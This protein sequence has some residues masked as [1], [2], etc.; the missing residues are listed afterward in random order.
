MMRAPAIERDAMNG[1][2]DDDLFT[3]SWIERKRKFVLLARKQRP[4]SGAPYSTATILDREASNAGDGA[5]TIKTIGAL[6]RLNW[7]LQLRPDYAE[8]S[9]VSSQRRLLSN[10][11]LKLTARMG[12]E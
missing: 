12:K 2:G 4:T 3:E 11:R 7:E 9:I 6:T 8:H 5:K 10:Y 1:S